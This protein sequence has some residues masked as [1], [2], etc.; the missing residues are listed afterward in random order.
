ML[1]HERREK[2]RFEPSPNALSAFF[3]CGLA[4]LFYFSL[5]EPMFRL[6]SA[7]VSVR[8]SEKRRYLLIFGILLLFQTGCRFQSANAV[9]HTLAD[10]CL[11]RALNA[12]KIG[13]YRAAQ[14]LIGISLNLEPANP[15]AYYIRGIV[16]L[17]Q[18]K[19]AQAAAH[20]TRALGCISLKKGAGD[21]ALVQFSKE[22]EWLFLFRGRSYANLGE[23]QKALAD[24]QRALQAAPDLAMAYFN[25]GVIYFSHQLYTEA[26][27]N[28]SQAVQYDPENWRACNYLGL[29]YNIRGE[30]GTAVA[31]F[32]QALE[33]K[34]DDVIYCNRGVAYANLGQYP[35]AVSDFSQAL[36][37]NAKSYDAHF[38]LGET[39]ALSKQPQKALAAYRSFL[40]LLPTGLESKD[41]L[42]HEHA[43]KA[44]KYLETPVN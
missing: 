40:R 27:A 21:S 20:F 10:F 7:N 38:L 34:P 43:K 29:L 32:S 5:G 19:N 17:D 11:A 41:A 6:T 13:E 3:P 36:K 42:V 44:V 16:F 8:I 14:S 12:E 39:F 31:V 15:M 35:E 25:L 1:A 18:G 9:R 2:A 4:Q 24:F 37:I 28:F 23:D 30:F 22:T 26:F 33:L